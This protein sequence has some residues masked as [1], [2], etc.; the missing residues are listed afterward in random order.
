MGLGTAQWQI[1]LAGTKMGNHRP[2]CVE[3]AFAIR[4]DY[5]SA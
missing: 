5:S 1:S 2:F 4:F 3:G